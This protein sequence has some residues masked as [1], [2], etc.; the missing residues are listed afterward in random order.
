MYYEKSITVPASATEEDPEVVEC[1]LCYGILRKVSLSFAAGV[2][3][4]TQISIHHWVRK[5]FP[6]HPDDHFSSN[7]FT[8]EF[9]E[10]YPLIDTP[11]TLTVKGWNDGGDYEHTIKIGF[12]V[13]KP[14]AAAVTEESPVTEDELRELLGEYEIEEEEKVG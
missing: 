5:L 12:L 3:R 9:E 10:Y 4:V 13:L 11:Y 8:I 14:G 6:T 2:H 1:A 7:D